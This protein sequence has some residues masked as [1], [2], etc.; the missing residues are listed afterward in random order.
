MV[1]TT[2]RES[3]SG[4]VGRVSQGAARWVESGSSQVGGAL[5]SLWLLLI[6]FLTPRHVHVTVGGLHWVSLPLLFQTNWK[7]L[8]SLCGTHFLAV[9]RIFKSTTSLSPS[10]KPQKFRDPSAW[11]V[12]L[13]TNPAQQENAPLKARR[14]QCISLPHSKSGHHQHTFKNQ[15]HF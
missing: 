15:S 4:Q 7:C 10:L 3:G 9:W 5:A 12:A 1:C 11:M 13:T 14:T 2:G 6:I 8:C